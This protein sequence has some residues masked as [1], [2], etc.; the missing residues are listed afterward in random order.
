MK[1]IDISKKESNSNH[2]SIQDVKC[3][4]H[5]NHIGAP[6]MTRAESQ[7]KQESQFSYHNS[8][9]GPIRLPYKESKSREELQSPPKKE[10]ATINASFF[11]RLSKTIPFP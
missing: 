1:S 8:S 3:T 7:I 2:T 5:L 6:S 9:S 10:K 11:H 4:F